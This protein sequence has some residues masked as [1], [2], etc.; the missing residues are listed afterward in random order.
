MAF[1]G[2]KKKRR[3]RPYVKNSTCYVRSS[4]R[5]TVTV[6]NQLDRAMCEIRRAKHALP[7][8]ARLGRDAYSVSIV[9]SVSIS[10]CHMYCKASWILSL[11]VLLTVTVSMSPYATCIVVFEL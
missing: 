5:K 4:K 8:R 7:A 3:D 10:V 9:G 1:A 2:S 6:W 11:F